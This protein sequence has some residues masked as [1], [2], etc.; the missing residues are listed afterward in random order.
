MKRQTRGMLTV[1]GSRS[2]IDPDWVEKLAPLGLDNPDSWSTFCDGEV[3]S[4]SKSTNSFKVTLLAREQVYFK[5]Y[6]Y[7]GRRLRSP[8]LPSKAVVEA[9]GLTQM[10]KAGCFT[11]EIVA[12]GERRV[13]GSIRAAHLVTRAIANTVTLAELAKQLSG[14]R[15]QNIQEWNQRVKFISAGLIPQLQT[16]HAAGIYH[17]DL[18]WRNLLVEQRVSGYRVHLIDCPRARRH[19]WRR[20]R[21]QVVDLSA[22][23]RLAITHLSEFQRLRFLK[24]YLGSEYDRVYARKLLRAVNAHLSRRPPRGWQP[25]GG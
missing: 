16:M 8:F 12:I 22:L 10:A 7:F 13:S 11:P 4:A 21:G 3:A 1:Q 17:Y 14:L 18:K 19:R 25:H 2:L 6:V 24:Q 15:E 23:S 5:R 20:F 9:W